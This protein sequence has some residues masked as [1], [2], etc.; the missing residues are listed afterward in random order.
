MLVI[1][2]VVAMGRGPTRGRPVWTMLGVAS[3][4]AIIVL[5]LATLFL[6]AAMLAPV[7]VV[8]VAI[9][10]LAAVGYTT[11]RLLRHLARPGDR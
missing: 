9:V 8:A 2:F 11:W 7:L 10:V 6:A 3:G 1:I 4:V 5:G